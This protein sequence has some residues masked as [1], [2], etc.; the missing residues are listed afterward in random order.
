MTSIDYARRH[1]HQTMAEEEFRN[2]HTLAI[3]L[4]LYGKGKIQSDLDKRDSAG[5]EEINKYLDEQNALFN[6][7]IKKLQLESEQ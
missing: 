4:N 2:I 6:E 3:I 7:N 1:I 5:T